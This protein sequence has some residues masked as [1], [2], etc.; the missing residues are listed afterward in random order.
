[1]LKLVPLLILTTLPCHAFNDDPDQYTGWNIELL[2]YGTVTEAKLH[3]FD[4][5][6]KPLFGWGAR[7]GYEFDGVSTIRVSA[8]KLD[9]SIDG[10]GFA[11]HDTDYQA[12]WVIGKTIDIFRGQLSF[13][14]YGF[15]GWHWGKVKY[16]N[17]V[18]K[19]SGFT[20]G[21]GLRFNVMRNL[22]LGA[23]WNKTKVV[24]EKLDSV[25]LSVGFKF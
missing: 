25:V 23:E 12:D 22:I 16:N 3:D 14:P 21:L 6:A 8:A 9:G 17:Q 18:Q 10:S 4:H 20:Y 24:S 19:D 7:I 11:L 13:K 2:K 5:E 1:M 15:A